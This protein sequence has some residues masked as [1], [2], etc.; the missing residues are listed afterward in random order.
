MSLRTQSVAVALVL[1]SG[2]L[3]IAPIAEAQQRGRNSPVQRSERFDD[4]TLDGFRDLDADG[5]GRITAAEWTYDRDDFRRADHNRD[6][7]LTQREFLGEVSDEPNRGVTEDD[8]VSSADDARFLGL[9][10]NHDDR[11]S[12][13]EWRSDRTSFDR[14][15]ENRDGYLTRAELASPDAAGNDFASLDRD[16]NGVISRGEWLQS[17]ASFQRL[18]SNRDGRLSASEYPGRSGGSTIGGSAPGAAQTTTQTQTAAY[19]AGYERGMVEGRTAG[20]EDRTRTG[21]WDLEGQ[22]E[23]EQADSGYRD[24][25]GARADFQ[26]GYRA[27]FRIGYRE[28]FGQR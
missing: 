6:G 28:G 17:A 9:D 20:H 24:T 13:S 4:W 18:D 14:L 22:R 25:L 5:N 23:L 2:G 15:D 7:V 21:T 11:V 12:R 19:R 27:A 8:D 3:A 1:T 26:A 10:A 16:G